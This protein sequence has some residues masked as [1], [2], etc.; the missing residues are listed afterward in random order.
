VEQAMRY[1]MKILAKIILPVLLSGAMYLYGESTNKIHYMSDLKEYKTLNDGSNDAWNIPGAGSQAI[2]L[3]ELL[4]YTLLHHPELKFYAWDVEGKDA[5]V[6]QSRKLSNPELETELENAGIDAFSISL[7]QLIELGGKRSS[8]IALA[9]LDK[10]ASVWEYEI[11]RLH[12][13]IETGQEYILA[14]K[15]QQMIDLLT[16]SIDYA[17][18]SYQEAQ[19]RKNAGAASEIDILQTQ[20]DLELVALERDKELNRFNSQLKLLAA[21]AGDTQASFS[22]VMGELEKPNVIPEFSDLISQ[23]SQSPEITA[24]MIKAESY[25]LIEKH[26]KAQNVPDISVSAGYARDNALG[27]NT[28]LFGFSLPLPLFDRNKGNITEAKINTY[29]A[30]FEKEALELRLYDDLLINYTEFE[31]IFKE[32]QVYSTS[33][34]PLAQTTYNEAKMFYAAGKISSL[35]LLS[36]QRELLEN[37]MYYINLLTDFYLTKYTLELLIGSEIM[38]ETGE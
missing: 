5:L 26:A 2:S 25:R 23:I 27:N 17:K 30:L 29:R 12:L 31:N 1:H 4:Q 10:N 21:Y 11:K 38:I 19:R 37:E 32:I 15:S 13:L 35:E 16:E 33:I 8:R 36:Y 34:L 22:H 9:K 7:G 24:W 14:L 3:N 6:L 20:K 28:F 18:T